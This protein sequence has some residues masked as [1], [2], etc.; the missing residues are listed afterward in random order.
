M[1]ADET[2]APKRTFVIGHPINHSRSPLIHGHWIKELGL[3]GSYEAIDVAPENLSNFAQRCR[4]GEFVGGNITIPHKEDIF[5]LC[6]EIDSDARRIGAVNTLVVQNGELW[7][8]NTDWHGFS[9]N[10]DDKLPEWD[11]KTDLAIILGAGGA[12]RAIIVALEKRG[13]KKIVILNR[14]V[15]RAR[16]LAQNLQ[17][18]GGAALVGDALSAFDNFADRAD[19]VVNTTSIG[20]HSTRFENVNLQNLASTAIVTDIVYV[21]LETPLLKDAKTL[22]L[23]TIDGLGMLLHQAVPGFEKWFGVRPKV[24]AK[25]R[26]LIEADMAQKL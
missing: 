14:S 26:A 24:S 2:Y 23:R 25:L 3:S 19:F 10:L 21:P 8:T 18:L 17:I 1:P 13:F 22:G 11:K 16:R 20:M 6:D 5:G 7:G 4:N 9:A 12:A 15:D